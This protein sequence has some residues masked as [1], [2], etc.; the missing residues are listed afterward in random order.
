MLR[1]LSAERGFEEIEEAFSLYK[2]SGV[3]ERESERPFLDRN[4]LRELSEKYAL[5]ERLS[6]RFFIAMDEIEGNPEICALFKFLR[7]DLCRYKKG[8]DGDFYLNFKLE[9]ESK[10]PDVRKFLLLLSCI[11]VGTEVLKERNVP[12]EI[13][14]NMPYYRIEPQMKQ[15]LETDNC[16]VLDFGWDKN[17]YALTIFLF[18]RF[19]FTPYTFGD[20]FRLYRNKKSDRVTGLYFG[21]A[22]V[23]RDGQLESDENKKDTLPGFETFYEEDDGAYRGNFMN[24]CGIISK[25]VMSLSKKD[26]EIALKP[27]DLLLAFHIPG[28]E[29]Y[30]PR[31]LEKSMTMALAFYEK[32]FP[33]MDIKGF[34]SESWLYDPRLS[35]LLDKDT[36]IVS[37][38]RRFYCYSIGAGSDMLQKELHV[39]PDSR[40]PVTSL[41]KK[42]L[43]VFKA[44]YDFHTTSMIVL[45][46][47]VPNIKD[48][49]PYLKDENIKE[50][51][52]VLKNAGID[53]LKVLED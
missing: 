13:Y 33:E 9:Y 10:C 22:G 14:E 28:G 44:G 40:D 34:W 11:S 42:A 25:K 23:T 52:A 18:D 6:D 51:K 53:I 4:L 3:W 7:W 48:R 37:M 47:D 32:Y 41:Q 35:M 29:G 1:Y 15:Y 31:R 46:D 50:Y 26:F 45:K 36:N 5:P 49:Y 16:E 38:Q 43:A 19:Y 2:G 8:I 21:G 39:T 20:P 17:F 12:G 30:N 27:G 24:P